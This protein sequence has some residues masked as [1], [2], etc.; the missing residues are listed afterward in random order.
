M[1]ILDEPTAALSQQE[2]D[3]LFEFLRRLRDQGTRD[4]LHHP[5]PRRGAR[6]LPTGSRCSATARSRL[7]ARPKD[8]DRRTLVEAMIGRSRGES[9]RRATWQLG[10]EPV[11]RVAGRELPTGVFADVDARASIPARSS[12]STA[13]SA[14]ARR[15]SPRLSSAC[16]AG[17]GRVLIAGSRQRPRARATS[18]PRGVGFVPGRPQARG[19]LRRPPV[20]ENVSA[21]PGRD[22]RFRFL[23]LRR[24]RRGLPALARR[25]LDPLAE[26]PAAAD[27]DA[28]GRESAEGRA[29]ALARARLTASRYGRADARGRRRRPR[30]ALPLDA[31]ARRRGHRDADLDLR[32]RG[33][34]P[35]RRPRVRHG[36]RLVV[37]ELEGDAITTS[38]ATEAAG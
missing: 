11:A 20:A 3:R 9:G 28:L 19:D 33:G 21:P 37:A 17:R 29:R 7:R 1:L 35:G 15:S 38:A 32:L 16:G 6:D 34:R 8:F 26:R 2:V 14:P 30:R 22:G 10:A 24:P 18:I 27:R 4:H 12:R 5:P 25:A 31:R 13:S 36:A 23:I